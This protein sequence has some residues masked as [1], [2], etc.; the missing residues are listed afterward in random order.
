MAPSSTPNK[1]LYERVIQAY[2]SGSSS[3][4]DSIKTL[5]SSIASAFEDSGPEAVETDLWTLWG[6]IID[7]AILTPAESVQSHDSLVSLVRGIKDL[8]QVD[9]QHP[10][11]S[12][13]WN[14][15]LWSDLPILGPCLRERW[16]DAPPKA[17]PDAWANLN[18]FVAKLVAADVYDASLYA[19]WSLREALETPRPLTSGSGDGAPKALQDVGLEDLL[20]A[21]LAWINGCGDRLVA[22]CV[23]EKSFGT[24]PDPSRLGPLARDGEV[25]GGVTQEARVGKVERTGFSVQRWLFWQSRMLAISELKGDAGR[26]EKAAKLARAVFEK[27]DSWKSQLGV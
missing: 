1:A 4:A 16:N 17:S 20:P 22:L 27:M 3:E 9:S 2:L 18:M 21:V 7:T 8:G 23:Q 13:A 12:D 15:R 6:A 11:A 24:G 10:E 25:G 14:G 5:T 26:S 19:I